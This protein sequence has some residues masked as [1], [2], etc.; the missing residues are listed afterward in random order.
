MS[1]AIEAKRALEKAFRN[2]R[3]GEVEIS[4]QE[5][6]SI[7]LSNNFQNVLEKVRKV[8]YRLRPVVNRK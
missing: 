1:E 6:A 8:M 5:I 4:E 7:L 2:R 3:L